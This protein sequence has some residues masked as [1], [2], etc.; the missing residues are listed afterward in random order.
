MTSN[1]DKLRDYLKRTTADL[2]KARRQLRDMEDRE[3]E[4]IAIVGMGC[5]FPGGVT[6]P[7]ELWQLLMDER[8]AVDGFP[9]DRGWDL[10]ELYDPEPGA[11]GKSYTKR[12]GFL[13]DA[14]DF[15][16]DFFEIS[17]RE[18]VAMDPQ[19][20]LLLE[21]SWEA[22]ERAGIDPTSVRGSRTGVFA[23]VMYQDHAGR[24]LQNAPEEFDGY[25]LTG[26]AGSVASGRVSYTLGLEGPAVAVDT[27]CS[28]SLV[29]VH[30]AA[31]A[32]RQ[33]ECT[34]ALA[35]GV[36]VMATP[37]LFIEFSRLRAL[38]VDGRC[39]AFAA[40]ADGAGWAEG[41]GMLL[42]ER[43]SDA[44]RNGHPVL[45]VLSG[46]AVN[47]DGASNGLTAPNGPSQERVIQDALA[48][49]R[50]APSEVDVVEAHGTGTSLGDPIEANALIATY[51]RGRDAD[52][53]L[54]L[55][56]V[57]SNIGHTQA[58]AGVAGVIKMVMAMRHGVLPKSLH[59]DEPTRHVDW[60]TGTVQL[61]TERREWP[62]GDRP[63]RAG[64]AS[65][66]I[67]GTNAHVIVEQAPAE[68]PA[69]PAENPGA[70][71][72]AEGTASTATASTPTTQ[73]GPAPATDG[74]VPWV[75]SAR[76]A[77]ALRGQAARLREALADEPEFDPAE[78]GAAL[79]SERT[80]FDHRAVVAGDGPER[81]LAGL[82]A[83]A[84]GGTAPGVVSGE[85]TP[86]PWAVM[87]TGQG[88]QRAGMGRELYERFP[89]FAAAF[90]AVCAELDPHLGRSLRELCFESEELDRTEYTQP[91]LFAVEVALYRLLESF[92]ARPDHLL[93]H[94]VGELAA[95]H[96]AGVFDLADA[97]RLVAARGRLMQALPAG[98]AMVAVQAPEDVVLRAIGG[99]TG[100]VAV[101][102]VNG[103]TSVVLSGAEEAVTAIAAAL[104][105]AG[106]RTKRLRVSHAFH[107]PLMDPMLDEFRQVARSVAYAEPVLPVVSDLTGA[108]AGPGELTDPEYWVRHVRGAVRF[109]DGVAALRALGVTAFVEVGPDAVLTA[110]AQET[111]ADETQADQTQADEAQAPAVLAT[112][113]RDRDEAT[114]LLAAVGGLLTRGV[115]VDWSSVLPARPA[116][117]VELPTYAFQRR[118]YWLES[119]SA[120][121]DVTTAGLGSIDHPLLGAVARLADGE[122]TVLT[123]RLSLGVQGW[124][125]D[126]AVAGTVILPGS[127]FV[128]LAVRAGDEVGLS[129]LDELVLHAPLVLVEG[130]AVRL[131]VT[132]GA[133]EGGE[134]RPVTVHSRPEEGDG[135]AWTLHAEGFLSGVV[136]A[137]EGLE[138]WP[139]AG[140]VPVAVDGVYE[141][142]AGL[143]LQYGPVF[144]GLGAAWRRGDDLFAEVRLPVEE[145]GGGFTLHPALLDAC[146]HLAAVEGEG[147]RLPFAWSGV[148]VHASGTTAA[149]VHLALSGGDGLSLRVADGAGVPVATVGSLSVR[150]LDP[151]QLAAVRSS[152]VHHVRWTALPV[153][154]A[155]AASAVEP[156]L[157]VAGDGGRGS[158]AG[159]VRVVA[160]EVLAALQAH[161]ADERVQD[162]RLV[163]VTRNAV[164]TGSGTGVQDAELDLVQS[165]VWGLVRSAIS[166]NPG[167]FAL[168]D[169]DATPASEQLV[170][171]A[172]ASP[173]QESALRDG[174]FLTPRLVRSAPAGEP[175]TAPWDPEG[176][177][178]ITGGTGGLGALLARHLVTTHGVRHLLLVSRSGPDATGA[179]E[180]TAELTGLGARTTIAA[181]DTADRDALAHVIAQVPAE[182]PLTAVVHTAGVLDDGIL[183]TLTPERL[184]TVL[185]PKVDAAWNLHE[186]TR[187]LPLTAFVLY[188]SLAGVLGNAGQAN[189]AAANTFLDTLAAHRRATG[190]PAHSLAW[191]LWAQTGAM[192]GELTE[193][194]LTRLARSGVHA[195]TADQGL[196][197][198]DTAL[199]TDH[200]LTVLAKLDPVALRSQAASGTVP[201]LLRGLAGVHRAT[202]RAGVEAGL[203]Q[204]LAALTGRD[205]TQALVDL[206]TTQVAA[207]IGQTDNSAISAQRPFRELGF[208]SLMAV[209]LRNR[210][211]K[212]TGLALATTL[213]FDHPSPLAIAELIERQISGGAKTVDTS[214]PAATIDDPIAI[215]GMACRFPGGV[216]SPEDL[217]QLVT[218]G[219]DGISTFPTDR[220]WDL[221]GLYHPDPDH[222]GTSYAREGGFLHGAAEFDPAFFG[223]SPREALTM[224]P[225]QRLL[226]ETSWEAFERAGIDPTT[227]R[228]SRTGVYAGVMYQDY[229]GRFLSHMPEEFEG[230]IGINGT[231][232]VA[233][234]RISYTLG[235]EGPAVTVDTACSSSLVAM[236]MAAQALQQGECTLALAGGV[237]V[238]ATP[239]GFVE[240]SRQ[241]AL[242]ADGRCK[243]FSSSADGTG[244]AEGVGLVLLERLSD[245]RRNGH[246]V[247]AVVRGTAINQDGAS[248]GLTAPNGPAQERVIRQALDRAGL[249]P[250]DVDAV[251]AHG[252]GTSLGD[253]IEANALLATY[254]QDREEPLWLGSLK[255]NIGH[256]QA[257]AGV[258]GVIKMV[259][260]MQHGVLPRTL[261]VEEPTHHVDWTVGAVRLL[262]EERAWP[263]AE[264]PRRAAVSAFGVSGTNAHV[265]LE[266]PATEATAEAVEVEGPTA[267]VVSATTPEA[268]SDQAARL[269]KALLTRPEA[270]A[271]QVAAA[272]VNSR[273][274]FDRRAVVVGSQREELL[275]GLAALARG[276]EAPG[277]VTGTAPEGGGRTVFVFPGQGSQWAGMGRDLYRDSPVFRTHLDTCARALDPHTGWD[278]VATLTGTDDTW[279]HHVDTVQPALFATMVALAQTWRTYGIEPDAVIG[280]SQ[281]E[282]AAA[283]IAGALTLDD[284]ARIVTLRSRTLKTLTGT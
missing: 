25:L 10:D 145:Q 246:Q 271:G 210:L 267:W 281:G 188:S 89:V 107:S 11:P 21:T 231:G 97:A 101:A 100:E 278:L 247:L 177:V 2:R 90:D 8:D 1:E 82:A 117:H 44:R 222:P 79:L 54:W 269:H 192:T 74:A 37:S 241:R 18:A 14:A 284:A 12:G 179:T 165:A 156:V 76:T 26:A 50:L 32:L 276:E 158:L 197:L 229:A 41:V 51:G 88:A 220:G 226:L 81:L 105:E 244:W 283:H 232:S 274:L 17:P 254:G 154:A 96:V 194:D 272:L 196:D 111:L 60:S 213:V 138:V 33:G 20:R 172:A 95:A 200:P 109:A 202:A 132:V 127:A 173:E 150:P 261:H 29:A 108:V 80:L 147:V 279:L 262:T 4:P 216:A 195:L 3:H 171:A 141:R 161:L 133:A 259:M 228:G 112:L 282:I 183:P 166:E 151:A 174:V 159:R 6:S 168:L 71:D 102:A 61:L 59:I 122:T 162:S 277:L 66:G 78:I 175:A 30:M 64:V 249:T 236:H 255:S 75:L 136:V 266:Q 126:H 237:T 69:E 118:H 135:E 207:V 265:I 258:G 260:A 84:D 116:R 180:L 167:R 178:L 24:F 190:L 204:R 62:A 39:K 253:P 224:D 58:A 40:G 72:D 152:D 99:N 221:E 280:H 155:P 63:R 252:T 119:P 46:S 227:V 214:A 91:A 223:I 49:A 217:W 212:A 275:T 160:G 238:M 53:P 208:D 48:S 129:T 164:P 28:S 94:S 23:G 65:M 70:A 36:T 42:L 225:Q 128:E 206:V 103:P 248:N 263:E 242:A 137:G 146:L 203:A 130:Q 43:L 157:F 233:S 169:T 257:A 142:L 5:R 264:R 139:P 123:G 31:Q 153:P 181:C 134:R 22:F 189:Y 243:A 198:F 27:A 148:A 144:R 124:L 92:G 215:V 34:L 113:R 38:S 149:R 176:T 106:H 19:Q 235:L 182:H 55:G 125:A 9:T 57:K 140:A 98:G 104:A 52:R 16:P 205:R 120:R 256:T 114:A 35:G 209:E 83:L 86:G 13:Y 251:E 163:V 47:Q 7:E 67:S 211:T 250:A 87:F 239:S 268:L 68:L 115:A 240:F 230:Q 219:R 187:D 234:G 143:G 15:D 131:Q 170:T 184:D 56:S 45:A 121:G 199:A 191:G 186:L 110:M 218:E 201:H 270:G 85:V 273:T 245:A 77:E 93:G 73:A 185:R 193:T